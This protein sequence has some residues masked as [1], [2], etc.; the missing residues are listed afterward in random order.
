MSR[1]LRRQKEGVVTSDRMSGT[2][3]VAVGLSRRHPVYKKVIRQRTK[4]MVDDPLNQAKV[5]DKVLIMETRPISKR[6]S[7][8]LVKVLEKSSA[9]G[10]V[11]EEV[12]DDSGLK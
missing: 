5:G 6:K 2:C 12:S 7:W 1:K 11:H 9:Q 4:I 3:V 10:K 8:R